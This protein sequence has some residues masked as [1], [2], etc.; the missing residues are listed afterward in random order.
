MAGSFTTSF[1]VTASGPGFIVLSETYERGNFRVTVNGR[2]TPYLRVNHAFR[3]VYVDAAGSYTVTFSYWPRGLAVAL[4]AAGAG[5]LLLAAALAV[6]F[7][8]HPAG[9]EA[10]AA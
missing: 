8:R 5:L 2:D 6:V 9:Q 1:T 4:A 7:L 10:R 3:G